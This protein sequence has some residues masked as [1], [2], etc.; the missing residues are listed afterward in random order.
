[1][2]CSPS[3]PHYGPELTTLLE[4]AELAP[5]DAGRPV[6]GVS[7]QLR[8]LL[9]TGRFAGLKIVDEAA[10]RACMA[11]LWLRFNEL[12]ESHRIS[13]ELHSS[14]GSYWHAIMHRREGD[15]GNSKFW[16]RQTG[17][18]PV[19][20]HLTEAVRELPAEYGTSGE[21]LPEAC[22]A[23]KSRPTWDPFRFVDACEAVVRGKL[24]AERWCRD[25]QQCE[26]QLL[27]D[28]CFTR[29]VQ[30]NEG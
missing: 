29:A 3:P 18:H 20:D 28:D 14:T 15:F 5:L 23:L 6:T 21:T 4:Q 9:R 25:V 27:F 13:Q 22:R 16:F 19:L 1:M 8:R 24:N 2:N 11:G 12:D 26:W 30:G 7:D 10:A 17:Q